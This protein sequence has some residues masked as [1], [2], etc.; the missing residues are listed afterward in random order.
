[1]RGDPSR[2]AGALPGSA[3]SNASSSESRPDA[4]DGRLGTDDREDLQDRRKPSIQLD[5]KPVIVVREPDPPRHP[6]PQ[7][8]QLM[9]QNRI[10]CS[11][12]TLR[13]EWRRRQIKEQK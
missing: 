9:S 3:T 12:L 7:N 6:A 8:N 10:L 11:E 5:K 1:M 4:N 2:F 13:P